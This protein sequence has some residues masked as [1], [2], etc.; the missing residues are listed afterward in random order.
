MCRKLDGGEALTRSRRQGPCCWETP[1]RGEDTFL[2]RISV[3]TG[4]GQCLCE[5]GDW[6]TF[7]AN[8]VSEHLGLEKNVE[9]PD[10]QTLGEKCPV[11]LN[12]C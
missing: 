5:S 9:A 10:L 11:V 4:K 1:D 7:P 12:K 6:D 2:V 8:S 3:P